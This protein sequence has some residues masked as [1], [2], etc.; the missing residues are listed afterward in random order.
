MAKRAN[1]PVT[2]PFQHLTALA[3]YVIRIAED[4]Y[5]SP[6][7]YDITSFIIQHT[8]PSYCVLIGREEYN[9]SPGSDWPLCHWHTGPP[10]STLHGA[11]VE[12][13]QRVSFRK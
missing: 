8:V 7:K 10:S 6:T 4:N 3:R 13:K 9:C 2:N 12:C 11:Q 1:L 5:H